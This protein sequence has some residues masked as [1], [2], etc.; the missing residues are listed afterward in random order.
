MTNINNTKNS[1]AEVIRPVKV[2]TEVTNVKPGL[3]FQTTA[4]IIIKEIAQGALSSG[5][6][7]EIEVGITDDLSFKRT[8]K[9]RRDVMLDSLVRAEVVEGDLKIKNQ[10]HR[11]GVLRFEVSSESTV[12]STIKMSKVAVRVDSCVDEHKEYKLFVGGSAISAY[13][14]DECFDEEP[15]YK[16]NERFDVEVITVAYVKVSN[17][18]C[19]F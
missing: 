19:D 4:D 13:K 7:N 16:K 18:P 17:T 10:Q 11:D 5:R 8:Y 2:K 3:Q 12:P 14:K 6:N 9:H 1:E 15:P